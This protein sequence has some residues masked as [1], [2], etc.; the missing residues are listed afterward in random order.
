MSKILAESLHEY[1]GSKESVNEATGLFG[2]LASQG[3]QFR[4]MFLPATYALIKKGEEDRVDSMMKWLKKLAELEY[5][6]DKDL[7]AKLGEK[8]FKVLSNVNKFLN[9]NLSSFA[10]TP[11][12]ANTSKKAD[13]GKSNEERLN[14]IAKVAGVDAQEIAN[15]LK[16][17]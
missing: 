6:G 11:G 7:K 13:T 1:R 2:D 4:K 12:G 8:N 14:A 16:K 3:K 17:G 15:M 10:A 9:N 5:P